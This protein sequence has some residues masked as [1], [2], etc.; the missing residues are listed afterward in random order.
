MNQ[1]GISADKVHA[2]H[3]QIEAVISVVDSRYT[4]L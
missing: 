1:P 2:V 4:Y 3:V